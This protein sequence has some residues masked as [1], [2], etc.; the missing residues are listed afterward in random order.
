MVKCSEC[1]GRMKRVHRTFLE[2]FRYAAVYECARCDEEE[3][4]PRHFMYHLGQYARCP[5]CG[6][7][8]LSKLKAL[9]KIDPMIKGLLNLLEKYNGG[10]LYHCRFCRIQFYDRREIAENDRRTVAPE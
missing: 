10:R 4:V 2:R 7:F 5:R 3:Y 9:D 8:R 1:G 6:T